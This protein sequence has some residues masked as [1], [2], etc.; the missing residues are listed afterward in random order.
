VR[1]QHNAAMAGAICTSCHCCSS[2]AVVAPT[3]HRFEQ[4]SRNG[5]PLS[6]V[7]ASESIDSD[8]DHKAKRRRVPS[9][10]GEQ[11][12]LQEVEDGW[13]LMHSESSNVNVTSFGDVAGEFSSPGVGEAE[14]D[15]VGSVKGVSLSQEYKDLK[16]SHYLLQAVSLLSRQIYGVLY[17]TAQPSEGL[18][19]EYLASVLGVSVDAVVDAARELVCYELVS[20]TIDQRTWAILEYW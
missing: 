13:Q 9:C 18:T 12:Q 5:S 20:A 11:E 8:L 7:T 17:F 2:G 16:S 3:D 19:A 1:G 10:S 4:R 14:A 15:C 6:F